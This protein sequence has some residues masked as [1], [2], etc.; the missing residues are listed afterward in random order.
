MKGRLFR[1][2]ALPVFIVSPAMAANLPLKAPPVPPVAVSG[3]TGFYI[4]ANAGY[5]FGQNSTSCSFTPGIGS[6]C[7]GAAFPDLKSRGG[8]LGVEAG[9]NWQYQDW[10]LGAAVDWSA[11]DVN[12]SAYFPSIDSGKS[13]QVASRYDWLGTARGRVGYAVGQSLFYGTGGLAFGRVNDSYGN[14]VLGTSLSNP[15]RVFNMAVDRTGWTAGAGW[16]YRMA[17]NWDFK[18][19][20]LHVD[21]GGTTLDISA[22]G[23]SGNSALGNPP[24]SSVVHFGNAFDLVRAGVDFRW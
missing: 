8:L 14:D 5:A 12:A 10:V 11:L 24:G 3:W 22:S 18:L 23:T 6:P 4:G 20:Y 15:A 13:N 7:Q 19:E 17:Q 2:I 1:G 21:L 9:A 16:E